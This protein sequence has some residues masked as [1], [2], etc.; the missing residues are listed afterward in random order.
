MWS[1]L[2]RSACSVDSNSAAS[3]TAELDS[4]SSLPHCHRLSSA[5]VSAAAGDA[6]KDT[7]RAQAQA[8]WLLNIVGTIDPCGIEQPTALSSC[9]AGSSSSSGL[10]LFALLPTVLLCR[11]ARSQ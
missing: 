9:N 4:S 5:V 1:M 3:A 6:S 8:A 10:N 2:E 7:D 11:V